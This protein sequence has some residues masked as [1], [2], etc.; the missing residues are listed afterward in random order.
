MT[1]YV[2]ISVSILR[3]ENMYCKHCGKNIYDLE[4]KEIELKMGFDL[5]GTEELISFR[6]IYCRET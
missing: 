1:K 2:K 5:D 3:R 6:K 4:N